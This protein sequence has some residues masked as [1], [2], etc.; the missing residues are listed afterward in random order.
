MSSQV[1]IQFEG[2]CVNIKRSDFPSLPAAHRIVLINASE[3]TDVWGNPIEKH[4]AGFSTDLDPKVPMFSLAGAA[5]QIV[6]PITTGLQTGVTYDPSY[7]DIPSLRALT[8]GLSPA[9]P[10]VLIGNNPELTACYFDVDFGT[11]FSTTSQFGAL[12][13]VVTILTDGDPQY[14]VTPFP[15]ALSSTPVQIPEPLPATNTMFF[16]NEED[17]VLGASNDDFMLS[18]LVVSPPPLLAPNLPQSPGAG[19]TP[20]RKASVLA[21]AAV[22]GL[23]GHTE[24]LS[25][26]GCSNSAYP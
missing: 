14:Q 9:S 2:I 20:N 26:V 11:I 18:Y 21:A 7:N 25:D 24:R 10:A 23:V 15:A 4:H 6:N 8:P 5:V 16:W 12:M 1:V 22:P 17:S 19:P 3:I 13:T